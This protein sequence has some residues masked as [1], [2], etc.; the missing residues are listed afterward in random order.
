MQKE[1]Q[2]FWSGVLRGAVAGA[3]KGFLIVGTLALAGAFLMGTNFAPSLTPT[4]VGEFFNM[5]WHFV[6]WGVMGGVIPG[7]ALGGAYEGVNSFLHEQEVQREITHMK[8]LEH[9]THLPIDLTNNEPAR[10]AAP[11]EVPEA[12]MHG[13]PLAARFTPPPASS[14]AERVM[15]QKQLAELNPPSQAIH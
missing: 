9:R 3:W 10:N 2:S 15:L 5:V 11:P 8:A 4:L 12:P 7:A 6:G 1:M 14:A 13:N